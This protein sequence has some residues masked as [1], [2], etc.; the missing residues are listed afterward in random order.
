MKFARPNIKPVAI[1]EL[2]QKFNLANEVSNINIS[3]L[4]HNTESIEPGDLFVALGGEKTHGANYLPTALK[5]GAVAVLT[6]LAGQEIIGKTE[7]PILITQNPRHI[8]GEVSSFVFG[9]PSKKLKILG[10]TGTNGK[11]T[12][13]WLLRDGLEKSGIP[14]SL[15]GTA[16][17]SIAGQELPSARTTP[18]APELQA[19]FAL[20]FEK[21]SKAIAMEVSSHAIALERINGTQFATVGFTNLSQDHLDF[22]ESMDKYFDT[23]ASLFTSKYSNNSV[24]TTTDSWGTQLAN[25]VQ[26]NNQKLGNDDTNDWR[27]CDIVAALGHVYFELIDPRKKSHKVTLSFAGAFNAFNAALAIA[28]GEQIGAD[29]KQFISGIKET[30]IPGRMQPV[31]IPDAALGIID[32]AH[33][34]N[35]IENV[36]NTL[37]EQTQGKLIVVLGAGGNRDAEKRPFM[38]QAAEKFADILIITDD[39]PREESSVKIR[40]EIIDGL[41][42]KIKI[43]EIENREEAIEFAVSQS[44]VSDTI[45]VLGKGHEATQEVSG[46]VI[47]F[48]DFEVLT[49]KLKAKFGQ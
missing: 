33:T 42:N 28:M 3:G 1:S 41:A 21:G 4:S 10:I 40:K 36:L 20:A 38:G 2:I 24:I 11:T 23:K 30:Q 26:I 25:Q 22:H 43:Q 16:G 19:L 14:T 9:E 29:T 35:A 46:K 34:P 47:K 31:V 39:N 7:I 49:K 48:D 45:A 18:E 6:D 15:L 17:I 32:Y 13:A 12:S 37:K 5:N 27:V 8:L 44:S